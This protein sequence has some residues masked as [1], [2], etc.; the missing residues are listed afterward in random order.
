[1]CHS[2]LS[3][4]KF[5]ACKNASESWL[6]VGLDSQNCA[7]AV[8]ERRLCEDNTCISIFDSCVED[9]DFGSDC[10]LFIPLS[11][12]ASPY[13]QEGGKSLYFVEN[14]TVTDFGNRLTVA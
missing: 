8:N 6:F 10:K 2:L 12:V 9:H 11:Y 1:M 7:T 14:E 5:I 3:P 13:K 4:G